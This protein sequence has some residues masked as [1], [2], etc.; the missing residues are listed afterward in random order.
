M[1]TISV[2]RD[3]SDSVWY[4]NAQYNPEWEKQHEVIKQVELS[5]EMLLNLRNLKYETLKTVLR[6]LLED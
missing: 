1:P 2:Y 6:E 5:D 4:T 3:C